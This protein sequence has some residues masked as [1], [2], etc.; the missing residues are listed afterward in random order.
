M[1]IWGV[2]NFSEYWKQPD[3]T[4]AGLTDGWVHTGTSAHS[5]EEGY[6]SSS[7]TG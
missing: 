5:D 1:W 4:S 6:V 7:P 3:A 2:M